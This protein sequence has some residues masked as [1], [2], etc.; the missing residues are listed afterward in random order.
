LDRDDWEPLY[1]DEELSSEDNEEEQDEDMSPF[2][3]PQPADVGGSPDAMDEEK[4]EPMNADALEPD[5]SLFY[6]LIDATVPASRRNTFLLFFRADVCE[7]LIRVFGTSTTCV[8]LRK[9]SKNVL[10]SADVATL[11]EPLA[12]AFDDDLTVPSMVYFIR[13]ATA[14][15]YRVSEEFRAVRDNLLGREPSYTPPDLKSCVGVLTAMTRCYF[16]VNPMPLHDAGFAEEIGRCVSYGVRDYLGST[17]MTAADCISVIHAYLSNS[18]S[19]LLATTASPPQAEASAIF[20][21]HVARGILYELMDA[22]QIDLPQAQ[23]LDVWVRTVLRSLIV[24]SLKTL[25]HFN[26]KKEMFAQK[27]MF[28]HVLL[29]RAIAAFVRDVAFDREECCPES[30]LELVKVNSSQLRRLIPSAMDD[31]RTAGANVLVGFAFVNK[32]MQPLNH[33]AATAETRKLW[34][35]SGPLPLNAPVFWSLYVLATSHPAAAA[36]SLRSLRH[37]H[38]AAEVNAQLVEDYRAD[39]SRARR[40]IRELQVESQGH[41]G[42][43]YRDL[44][45][46]VARRPGLKSL[47]AAETM[48]I[49]E[50]DLELL[51]PALKTL[52]DR[53]YCNISLDIVR[54]CPVQLRLQNGSLSSRVYELAAVEDWVRTCGSASAGMKDPNSREHLDLTH[55]SGPYVQTDLLWMTFQQVIGSIRDLKAR[56]KQEQ[57]KNS[58]GTASPVRSACSEPVKKVQ[59]SSKRVPT[60]SEGPRKRM[61]V[62]PAASMAVSDV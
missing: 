56:E 9:A 60:D 35:E 7:P 51:P 33:H 25:L 49:E 13:V 42:E 18:I 16:R 54:K 21:G 39:L 20:L 29:C 53:L 32:D 40:T 26:L 11:R 30:E 44:V 8:Q 28:A 36:S 19:Q 41:N 55:P 61:R 15:H 52:A 31:F 58:A 4:E 5:A 50:E 23:S 38:Q 10:T 22:T 3:S 34:C 17:K 59:G 24:T 14:F 62:P 6:R 47:D 48:D 1:S 2:G 12:G 43:Y 27:E 46:A 37:L 45:A 57:K